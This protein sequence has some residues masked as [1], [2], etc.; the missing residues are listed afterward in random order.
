MQVKGALTPGSIKF[1]KVVAASVNA[2]I[3]DLEEATVTSTL[4]SE[5]K[6]T[7]SINADSLVSAIMSISAAAA[8]KQSAAI[9]SI[10]SEAA[11]PN[12]NEE[13]DDPGMR[14]SFETTISFLAPCD[15]VARKCSSLKRPIAEIS[16]ATADR[17]NLND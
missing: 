15:L 8:K 1:K 14:D 3:A 2:K 4:T 11:L 12:E 13:K 5:T 16:I 10:A 6:N 7:N 9:A 17:K